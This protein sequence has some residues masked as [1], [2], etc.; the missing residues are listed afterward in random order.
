MWTPCNNTFTLA[1]RCNAHYKRHYGAG[2]KRGCGVL[3]LGMGKCLADVTVVR[4]I[5]L[6]Y[7]GLLLMHGVPRLSVVRMYVEII[8]GTMKTFLL[9]IFM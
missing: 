8:Q 6:E 4:I 5:M 1:P 2:S 3:L 7:C 9:V